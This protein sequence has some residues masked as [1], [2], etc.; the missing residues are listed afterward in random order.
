MTSL[1]IINWH[2]QNNKQ[3][4]KLKNKN[5][6]LS[7]IEY[8]HLKHLDLN[9]AHDDYIEEL[10]LDTKPCLPY[11]VNLHIDYKALKSNI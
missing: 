9:E 3:H 10:L 6:P 8:S 5:Q 2:A 4:R 7:I 1:S 11:D